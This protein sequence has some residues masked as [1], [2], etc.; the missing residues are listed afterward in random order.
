MSNDLPSGE[1]FARICAES[2]DQGMNEHAAV[3][4]AALIIAAWMIARS[5]EAITAKT[6]SELRTSLDQVYRQLEQMAEIM[7]FRPT[8][9][10]MMPPDDMPSGLFRSQEPP[11]YDDADIAELAKAIGGLCEGHRDGL[12]LEALLAVIFDV[13]KQTAA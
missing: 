8:G 2:R 13:L 6:F 7:R 5:D 10:P 11:Q 12:I 9:A 4:Q 1:T 3:T